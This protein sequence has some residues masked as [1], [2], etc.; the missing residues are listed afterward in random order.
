MY[1]GKPTGLQVLRFLE[2]Q[3]ALIRHVHV[4]SHEGL[5]NPLQQE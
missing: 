5:F 4:H 1:E 2:Y 3:G